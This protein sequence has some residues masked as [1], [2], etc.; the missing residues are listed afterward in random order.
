VRLVGYVLIELAVGA[1]LLAGAGLG[2]YHGARELDRFVGDAH[3]AQ[4]PRAE[5]Q[6]RP[7]LTYPGP[8]GAAPAAKGRGYF[9]GVK[10]EILLAPLLEGEVTRVKFNRGG[11]SVSLRID[12]TGGGRAAFKPEQ[13]NLQSLPR[14]EIAAYRVSRLL[15]LEAVA[16]AVGRRLPL[17]HLLDNLDA[18]S[19]DMLERI[20]TEVVPDA[21]GMVPGELSWWIPVIVDAKLEGQLI[22]APE[23][24]GAWRRYLAVGAPEPY[25]ARH[26]LPQISSMVVFDYLINNSDRFS[27]SNAKTSPDGRT[28]FYMDNTLS[29]GADLEGSPKVR[30]YLEK[31]Q[32]FSRALVRRVRELDERAVRE[33]M[34]RDTGPYERLLSDGEIGAVLYRREQLVAYW[35]GLIAAHGA[36]NVLV[37]P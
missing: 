25:A 9:L 27:G 5:R 14:R 22:D 13:I 7:H 8:E 16:P 33:A 17:K 3:A 24:I 28:L 37:Y 6:P 34:T 30:I 29:F 12:F 10:D 26:L 35:D 2:V 23:G 11:S 18:G 4:A 15:G 32:K 19:R 36:Q 21:E 1:T 20:R 31:V